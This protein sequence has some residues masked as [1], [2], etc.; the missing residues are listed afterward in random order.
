MTK[1]TIKSYLLAI[2]A[3]FLILG[4][5]SRLELTHQLVIYPHDLLILVYLLL[6]F[7][8]IN[9][10]F[11]K[12][13]T[14]VIPFFGWLGFTAFI[15]FAFF[16]QNL[17]LLHFLRTS[18]Y[19][20][21]LVLTSSTFNKRNVKLNVFIANLPT[22]TTIVAIAMYIF[23]PDMR[24]LSILGWDDHYYR[25]IGPL[26]D[27]NFMGIIICIGIILTIKQLCSNH[28]RSDQRLIRLVQLC[29]FSVSLGL[30]FSRSSFLALSAS[31]LIL[32]GLNLINK[33][34]LTWKIFSKFAITTTII[35]ATLCFAPKPGGAGV[36][37]ARSYSIWSR[38]YYD[39]QW[40]SFNPNSIAD[41]LIGPTT[42]PNDPFTTAHAH[43][44]NNLLASIYA[45]SGPIGVMLFFAFVIKSIK[46][47]QQKIW[48]L[49]CLGAVLVF[50]QANSVT[51]PFVFL[52][53]G[54]TLIL[55]N[56][57]DN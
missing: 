15:K 45:W 12:K 5:L 14:L 16:H 25:L 53:L 39:R 37:L 57:L 35:I 49:A 13:L 17:F 8:Q 34:K 56:K 43:L 30:T 3:F 18:I 46:K 42:T 20:L 27:P 10:N 54:L 24:M 52:I 51:E 23:S 11:R 29:F 33:Q 22:F 55:T 19:F 7:K 4:Q 9:G 32:I 31:V 44:P 50:T 21:F 36:N 40:L 2:I 47:Y 48:L 41:W 26:F 1:L 6:S 28:Q 38:A